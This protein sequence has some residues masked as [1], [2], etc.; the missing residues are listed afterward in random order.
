[1]K[2]SI[3]AATDN[4]IKFILVIIVVGIF[5]LLIAF[6]VI[7]AQAKNTNFYFIS[8]NCGNWKTE[9]QC[10]Q[11]S[12]ETIKVDGDKSLKY[13]CEKEYGSSNWY[14]GCKELCHCNI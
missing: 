5:L 14:N 1:M 10:S 11:A 3:N 6:N 12:A 2:G 8:M 9:N 4:T 13:Y 7:P